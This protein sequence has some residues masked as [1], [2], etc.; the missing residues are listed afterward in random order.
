M[1]DIV[2]DTGIDS[3]NSRRCYS[4]YV[5]G[6]D[7]DI[8]YV[9]YIGAFFDLVFSR[10]V[11]G[12]NT[13][14]A[15]TFVNVGNVVK[16]QVWYDRWT[17][18][19]TGRLIHIILLDTGLNNLSYYSLDTIDNNLSAEVVIDTP[20]IPAGATYAQNQATIAKARGGNLLVQYWGDAA[21]SRGVWRSTD[22]GVTWTPRADGA[23]GNAVDGVMMF[24]GNEID[25]QDMWMAYLDVSANELFLKVYDDSNNSWSKALIVTGITESTILW[26]YAGAIRHSD[27]HLLLAVWTRIDNPAADILTFDINGGA[28]IVPMAD[29]VTDLAESGNICLTINQQNGNVFVGYN[30]GGVWSSTVDSVYKA[31]TDGMASWGFEKPMSEDAADDY[32]SLSSTLSIGDEGGKF[33]P[34]W[35]N[36]DLSEML[37]NVNNAVSVDVAPVLPQF[38]QLRS[39]IGQPPVF[40]A[41]IVRS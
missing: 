8:Q 1:V 19:D 15:P 37:V 35:E 34:S 17:P 33:L 5:V 18:N 7:Q 4:R 32:R 28:S 26:Q 16:F 41:T 36:I 25:D 22:G 38:A 11:D 31:S 6:V 39:A 23:D 9:F 2:V 3:T 29:V 20:L 24:P 13:W 40:G 21:G 12:G 14:S 10:S 27:N 30:R